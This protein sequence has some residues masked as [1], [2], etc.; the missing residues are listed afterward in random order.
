[1]VIILL[2]FCVYVVIVYNIWIDRKKRYLYL[3]DITPTVLY[4]TLYL[5]NTCICIQ[6][7]FSAWAQPMRDN[8]TM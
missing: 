4:M 3:F 5:L 2:Y 1:M 7:S 8:V 6:R